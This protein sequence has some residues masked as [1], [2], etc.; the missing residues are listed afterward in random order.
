MVLVRASRAFPSLDVVVVAA[1]LAV[2]PA[3]KQLRD[4]LEV[5]VVSPDEEFE[6]PLFLAGPALQGGS[7]HWRGINSCLI[8][9]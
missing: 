2:A 8:K 6:P 4:P 3:R 9:S 5:P 7:V 1:D